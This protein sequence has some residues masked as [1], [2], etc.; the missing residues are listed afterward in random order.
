MLSVDDHPD[1]DGRAPAPSAW[2]WLLVVTAALPAVLTGDVARRVLA[3]G[4]D[5]YYSG[6]GTGD[7]PPA[8]LTQRWEYLQFDV[9][10]EG[11]ALTSA[12]ALVVV[13]ALVLTGRPAVLVPGRAARWLAVGV[14]A[15]TA[16]VGLGALV[17]MLAYA[18]RDVPAGEQ[19]GGYTRTPP[20][21]LAMAPRVG[22]AVLAV[23]LA[24]LATVVVLRPGVFAGQPPA[25]EP[26]EDAAP[27]ETSAAA[28]PPADRGVPVEPPAPP[29]VAPPVVP[30]VAG[31]E[32]SPVGG[33]VDPVVALPHLSED[34]LD[35]YRRPRTTPAARP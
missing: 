12:L 15:V 17:G 32:P 16:L 1:D 18:A 19:A 24:V 30:A 7:V 34:E 25:E 14:G 4:L 29:V 2:A 33:P 21:Y 23:V 31:P 8:T 20:D 28:Q 5:S 22:V 10:L 9:S 3:G 6:G 27:G 11:G 26:A 35:L 13:A